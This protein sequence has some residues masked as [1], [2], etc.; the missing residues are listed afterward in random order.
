MLKTSKPS[1]KVIAEVTILT[2][3]SWHMRYLHVLG[4]LMCSIKKGKNIWGLNGGSNV[5]KLGEPTINR[6]YLLETMINNM[7]LIELTEETLA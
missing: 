5:M 7:L 4:K 1:G 2:S 6:C 3:T